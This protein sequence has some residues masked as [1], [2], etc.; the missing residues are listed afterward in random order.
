MHSKIDTLFA[1]LWQDYLS[2]TPSAHKIHQLLGEHE[3]AGNAALVN[4]H[5]ALRT[6]NF[7][8]V[9]LDK[10]AA[11]FLALGYEE[12]GQYTFEK[13]KLRAKHFEHANNNKPSPLQPE[14]PEQVVETVVKKPKRTA[15]R[16]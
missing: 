6:F 10:L 1:N 5:I 15:I 9:N 14:Y 16:F 2:I 12:K 13:K 8:K 7:E 11:H 3:G 4:D